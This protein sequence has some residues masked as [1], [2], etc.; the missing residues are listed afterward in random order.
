MSIKADLYTQDR[1]IRRGAYVR[2]PYIGQHGW[3][4]VEAG[5]ELDWDEVEELVVDGYRHAA[6][7]RLLKL[8][9]AR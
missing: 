6:P 4:S 5:S 8:L 2:T 1:L 9:D 7:K 3:V